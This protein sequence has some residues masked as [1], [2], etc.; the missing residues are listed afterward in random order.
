MH[1]SEVEE[2]VPLVWL[3]ERVGFTEMLRE[4]LRLLGL[5]LNG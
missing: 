4:F 3:L 5:L 1:N 2:C